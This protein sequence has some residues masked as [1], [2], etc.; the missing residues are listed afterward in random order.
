MDINELFDGIIK[1]INPFT[2]EIAKQRLQEKIQESGQGSGNGVRIRRILRFAIYDF[3]VLRPALY[4][5]SRRIVRLG[6]QA[7][8]KR[9][10]SAP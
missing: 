9:G 10:A 8:E 6:I 1:S 4:A 7:K 2:D 5:F 3:S